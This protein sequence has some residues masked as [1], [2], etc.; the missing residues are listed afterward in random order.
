LKW[1]T[2]KERPSLSCYFYGF[3]HIYA[4]CKIIRIL[5]AK[6]PY[7][8]DE[9]YL[10]LGNILINA[11]VMFNLIINLEKHISRIWSKNGI[12]ALSTTWWYTKQYGTRQTQSITLWY[13]NCHYCLNLW[14]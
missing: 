13:L 8:W 14:N 4:I 12:I 2:S 7:L 3:L 10:L 9:L 5:I 1:V 11:F 6:F